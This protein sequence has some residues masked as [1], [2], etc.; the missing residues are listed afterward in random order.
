MGVTKTYRASL[1]AMSLILF[2]TQALAQ[3]QTS[4]QTDAQVWAE[5]EIIVVAHPKGP[6]VWKLKS[7]TAVVYVLGAMPVM[8]KRAQWDMG[9]MDYLSKNVD[10]FLTKPEARIGVMGALT[11]S[12]QMNLGFGESLDSVLPTDLARRF[13]NMAKAYGL[14]YKKYANLKPIA[15]AI[16][17]RDDIYD[18]AELSTS[19]P[20]K[21]IVRMAKAAKTTMRP[22]ASFS[23]ADVLGKITHFSRG[24]QLA[25]TTNILNEVDFATQYAKTAT[26]YWGKGDVRD[27]LKYQVNSAALNCLEGDASTARVLDRTIDESVAQLDDQLKKGGKALIILPMSTLLAKDGVLAKLRAKGVEISEPETN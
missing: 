13:K 18:K 12:T 1:A 22:V 26:N 8:Q 16:R 27:A 21:V 24:E 10:L 25:C 2:S 3:A 7:G 20:E 19:D 5:P 11:L 15:A 9:R 4:A 14:D 6:A 17:L 23:A